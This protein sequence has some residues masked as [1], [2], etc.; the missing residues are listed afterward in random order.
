MSEVFIKNFKLNNELNTTKLPSFQLE[1]SAFQFSL[2]LRPNVCV[3]CLTCLTCAGRYGTNDCQCTATEI[4]WNKKKLGYKVEFRRRSI[5]PNN[6]VFMSWLKANL[7][8]RLIWDESCKEV[9]LLFNEDI[10]GNKLSPGSGRFRSSNITTSKRSPVS[11][12][13]ASK[14]VQDC[15][16]SSDSFLV[17]QLKSPISSLST[18]NNVT[19]CQDYVKSETNTILPPLPSQTTTPHN[20]KIRK[21]ITARNTPPSLEDDDR[22][23]QFSSP[24]PSP[25]LQTPSNG[26]IAPLVTYDLAQLIASASPKEII[27]L[28]TVTLRVGKKIVKDRIMID[29]KITFNNLIQS[30]VLSSPPAGKRYVIKSMDKQYEYLPDDFVSQTFRG[31][32]HV[33]LYLDH[34]SV[35]SINL[36]DFDV[37]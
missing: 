10:S 24:S 28:R 15:I 11:K 8:Q 22:R 32:E 34:E 21:N 18:Q 17:S 1:K 36:G 29:S 37:C 19:L 12:M 25:R 27:P 14:R 26:D 35:P 16:V 9:K 13:T 2:P 20:T 4:Q 23:C 5:I 30:A 7:S 31:I 6:R 33:E 3:T